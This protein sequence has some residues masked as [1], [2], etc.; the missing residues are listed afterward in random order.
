MKRSTTLLLL[1]VVGW[2]VSHYGGG[3]NG[4]QSAGRRAAFSP[5]VSRKQSSSLAAISPEHAA[6]LA[7]DIHSTIQ[8]HLPHALMDGVSSTTLADAAAA[9]LTPPGADGSLADTVVEQMSNLDT[10]ISQ[11]IVDAV[12]K[13]KADAADKGWWLTYIDVFK[14]ALETVHNKIDG[15]LR[16]VGITQTWG[17]S[18]AVFT[19]CKFEKM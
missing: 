3:V 7:H 13:V 9:V 18:I 6:Q 4:F 12:E 11:D 2:T 15:P 17:V 8:L 1:N 16:S 19:A 10:G 14:N 5:I